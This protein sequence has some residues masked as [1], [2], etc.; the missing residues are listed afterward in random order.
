MPEYSEAM[1]EISGYPKALSHAGT[2]GGGITPKVLNVTVSEDSNAVANIQTIED[3]YYEI[4]YIGIGETKA[5]K[6]IA[7][8]EGEGISTPI[9][10]QNGG[11]ITLTGPEGVEYD[12]GYINVSDTV[13]DGA[14]VTLKIE[15]SLLPPDDDHPLG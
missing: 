14:A 4:A 15:N 6:Y 2:G 13:A 5:V 3:N 7:W 11:T 12:S 8:P 10:L 1:S 9:E